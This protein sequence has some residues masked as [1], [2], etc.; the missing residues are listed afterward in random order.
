MYHA[1]SDQKR[2]RVAIIILDKVGLK[3]ILPEIS[4]FYNNERVSRL[5]CNNYI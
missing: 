5:G 2:T 1:N 3:T 4:T